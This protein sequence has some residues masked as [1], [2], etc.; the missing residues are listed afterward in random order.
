MF[1]LLFNSDMESQLKMKS[2]VQP[3][4]SKQVNRQLKFGGSAVPSS[5]KSGAEKQAYLRV[6]K[7]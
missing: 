7:I 3:G 5:A 2:G 4:Q 6:T 1:L